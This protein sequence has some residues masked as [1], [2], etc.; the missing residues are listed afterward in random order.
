[1][2]G[3][4]WKVWPAV[5]MANAERYRSGE[6]GQVWGITHRSIPTLPLS[7]A[8]PAGQVRIAVGLDDPESIG[9]LRHYGFSNLVLLERG[10][11]IAVLGIAAPR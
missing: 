8:V 6:Q 4:Y 9:W 7:T 1:V 2:A 11:K 10:E 3:N 5:V